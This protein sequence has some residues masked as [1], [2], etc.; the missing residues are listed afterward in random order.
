MRIALTLLLLF[1]IPTLPA[2][3]QSRTE[4]SLLNAISVVGPEFRETITKVSA[5]E[6]DPNPGTW[7]LFALKGSTTGAVYSLEVSGGELTRARPSFNLK[8]LFARPTPLNL[9]K[10]VVDS[11][12][13]FEIARD[14]SA[15]NGRQLGNVSFILTQEGKAAA[16][17]W[18]IWCYDLRGDYFAYLEVSAF[19]GE[20]LASQN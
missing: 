5:D 17:V 12:E 19:S 6:A 13:A 11:P 18:Q 7:Y 14:F 4:N 16:P 15:K 20:I 2:A 1:V 9:E 10:L 8:Q 3:A